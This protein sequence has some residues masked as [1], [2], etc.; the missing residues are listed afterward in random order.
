MCVIK[1]LIFFG[2]KKD[3]SVHRMVVRFL[4]ITIA[5]FMPLIN[6]SAKKLIKLSISFKSSNLVGTRDTF[7]RV[8]SKLDVKMTNRVDIELSKYVHIVQYRHHRGL[9]ISGYV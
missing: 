4:F 7:F 8:L 3:S 1:D 6:L 5:F 9:E 2:K